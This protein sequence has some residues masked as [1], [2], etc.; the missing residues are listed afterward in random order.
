MKIK[1][2]KLNF[3][4]PLCGS[5]LFSVSCKEAR[6]NDGEKEKVLRETEFCMVVTSCENRPLCN[7]FCYFICAER[8]TYISYEKVLDLVDVSPKE[9]SATCENYNIVYQELFEKIYSKIPTINSGFK[10]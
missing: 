4:C 7:I 6:E 2:K 1:R 8:N 5:S 3:K 9:F 10:V